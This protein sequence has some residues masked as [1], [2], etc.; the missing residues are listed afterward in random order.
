[1]VVEYMLLFMISVMIILAPFI[2]KKGPVTMMGRSGPVL[3]MKVEQALETGHGFSSD[4]NGQSLT[5]KRR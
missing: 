4:R 2:Q 3:G 5:W 1:M